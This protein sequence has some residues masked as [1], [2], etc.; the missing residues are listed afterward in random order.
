MADSGTFGAPMAGLMA[1]IWI[2]LNTSGT[3]VSSAA[4]AEILTIDG[5]MAKVDGLR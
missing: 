3:P 2:L 5:G 4:D 1:G